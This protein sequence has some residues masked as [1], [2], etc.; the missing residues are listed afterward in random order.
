MP[1]K[2]MRMLELKSQAM[3]D[4]SQ[5]LV[6]AAQG[7]DEA[8]M[9]QAFEQF[10]QIIQQEI[11]AEAEKFSG[12]TDVTVLAQRGV[13]QLTADE[14]KFYNALSEAYKS[15]KPQQALTDLDVVMPETIIDDVFTDLETNHPLLAAIDF[16]FGVG[17]TSWL[18]N[19]N[20][21][22][23]ATWSPL[24]AE[25]VKELTSGFRE[26]NLTQNKLSAFLPA[27]KAMLDLG[28]QWLDRYVRAVLAEALA[29]GL[30]YGIL[31]GRGQV[32]GS[33]ENPDIAEPIGAR[34]N[35]AGTISPTTGYPDKTK[36]VVTSLDAVSYGALAAKLATGENGKIRTVTDLI[37]VV[38]PIDYLTKIMPATT[39]RTPEGRY[40]NN[41]LPMPTQIVQ[42]TQ[43]AQGEAI[44]GIAS[45]YI[46]I[47]GSGKSGKIDYS[48][49]Y[50][51][52]E[53]NRV[54][55]TK[56]YGHGQPKDNNSFLLLDI[57]GLQPLV[58]QVYVTNLEDVPTP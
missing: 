29:L 23:L 19:K 41:V 52:L 30:E 16:K 33:G 7:N 44:F 6:K 43:V 46:M 10:G 53:D 24:C 56:F 49:H 1:K 17:L 50:Q 35:L 2:T 26:I 57:S 36:E 12:T 20:P 22:Q 51:F 39:I 48:D 45:Q 54:Y 31:N 8:E 15:N 27:C 34:K 14:T 58:Q 40:V 37:L 28:P 42:S 4:A 3:T 38:N 5:A 18:L 55:L 47:S 13:R 21:N 11:L 32:A 25:I 9:Q